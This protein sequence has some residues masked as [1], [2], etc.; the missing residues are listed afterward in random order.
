[1]SAPATRPRKRRKPRSNSIGQVF[2]RGLK[3]QREGQRLSQAELAKRLVE[4]GHGMHQTAIAKIETN[5]RTVSLQDA[6]ALAA[7]LNVSP[8]YLI[9]GDYSMEKTVA[10]THKLKVS[11][12]QVRQWVRG[13]RALPG[14]DPFVFM[15]EISRDEAAASWGETDV[16]AVLSL[17]QQLTDA[18][19]DGEHELAQKLLA[20]LRNELDRQE[21]A[22]GLRE[23]Q[24]G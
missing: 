7:A 21:D 16:H 10:V 5:D 6:M 23:L 4:L 1:M 2:A 20:N 17:A 15:K 13:T 24:R 12:R 18:T 8:A 9:S 11:P 19:I 3:A 14:Q 22:A